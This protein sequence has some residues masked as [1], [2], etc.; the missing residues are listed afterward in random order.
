MSN[1]KYNAAAAGLTLAAIDGAQMMIESLRKDREYL[2]NALAAARLEIASLQAQLEAVGAGGVGPLG[3]APAQPVAPEDSAVFDFW[4]ADHMPQ[5]DKSEAWA[6]WC[7]LRS[8][9]LAPQPAAQAGW[10][11]G[12]SPDNCGGCATSV[13][14]VPAVQQ[15][16][17]RYRWLREY[18]I[19]AYI[20]AQGKGSTAIYLLTK[21]PAL[22]GIGEETDAAIDAARGAVPVDAVVQRDAE[23]YQWLRNNRNWHVT[24][25]IRPGKAIEYAMVDECDRWGPWWPTHEQAIDA[26]RAAQGGAA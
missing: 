7:A 12:C 10:C 11:D 20:T 22:D 26:A 15:D 14:P 9:R 19:G 4:R 8:T 25:R 13:A 2:S 23:R 16:A 17:E 5:S 21:V 3:G 18:A 1:E 24:Y 6:E